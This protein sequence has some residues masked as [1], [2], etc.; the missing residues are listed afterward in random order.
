MLLQPALIIAT[1]GLGGAGVHV[2][3]GGGPPQGGALP[4]GGAARLSSTVRVVAGKR[5]SY[6]AICEFIVISC[7]E[8]DKTVVP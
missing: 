5:L 8:N 6:A 3:S 2:R 4:K 7:E 1:G